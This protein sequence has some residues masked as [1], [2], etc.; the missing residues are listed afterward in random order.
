MNE[1]AANGGEPIQIG[2][3]GRVGKELP[4]LP[5]GL[6]GPFALNGYVTVEKEGAGLRVGLGSRTRAIAAKWR[7]VLP[8]DSNAG[9]K[10]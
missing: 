7:I 8:A 1:I 3:Y 5:Q 9:G 10:G 4:R 6:I 2:E